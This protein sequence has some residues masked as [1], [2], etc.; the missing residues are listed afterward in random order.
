M[1]RLLVT[2]FM[3]TV[4]VSVFALKKDPAYRDARRS[5]ALAKIQIRV[6]DDLGQNV[7]NADVN[8]FMG[9]N[10]RPQGY[11]LK[12]ITNTNGIFVAEGKTCG[13]EV[14]IDVNKQGH[15]SSSK[16]LCFAEMGHEHEVKDGKWL[17]YGAVETL[18]LRPIH[19]PVALCSFGFGAGKDVPSTNIWIG[20]DMA[21]GDFI[22]PYGKG[23]RADFEVM[24]EWDGRPPV[25]S[26]HC[27]AHLRFVGL[28]SGGYYAA[29]VQ[30]SEYPYVY[31][32]N[33]NNNFSLRHVK[34]ICRGE[35]RQ[36]KEC[37]LGNGNV[38]V[39]RTRCVLD[40]KGRL[41]SAC[42]GFIR[43]FDADASW[44]GN[45]TMRLAWIFNGNENDTN[46]EAR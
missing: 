23:E 30:E 13:D 11:Y 10:F 5:G 20:V 22:K 16:K 43:I 2:L 8:V 42:Y 41:K 28:L 36:D 38:L 9:M 29:N 15:Y 7:P 4:A 21:C 12:G 26:K 31:R 3:V 1:K 35:E 37:P 6:V 18:Q 32:A 25:D 33:A 34:V 46:L 40:E 45:P 17:P 14:V 39:T 44:D 27:T 24:V 19:N